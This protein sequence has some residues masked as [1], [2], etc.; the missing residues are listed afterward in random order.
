VYSGRLWEHQ[1]RADL[2]VQ[3]LIHACR[4]GNGALVATVIGDGYSRAACEQQVQQAGLAER[5]RFTGRLPFADLQRILLESQ[6]ILLMSDFEGLPVALLEAMAAGLVPVVRNIASGIPEVVHQGHTG[7]LVSEDPAEAAAAL[8]GLANDPFLWQRCSEA[9]R[10]LVEER[11]S[12]HRCHQL[13]LDLLLQLS[14][15]AQPI[16]PI[17][18]WRGVKLSGLSPLMSASYSRPR[19]T[20]LLRLRQGLNTRSAQL[21]GWLKRRLSSQA[22]A[23]STADQAN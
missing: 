12:S 20:P 5:I 4:Q 18:D 23:A 19:S 14:T 22:Q 21:K 2:V 9:S 15:G 8:L 6:A 7:L 17:A 10:Q 1:K 3:T 11:F 16:Y 13:W